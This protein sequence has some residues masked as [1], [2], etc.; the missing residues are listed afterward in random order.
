MLARWHDNALCVPVVVVASRWTLKV[1]VLLAMNVVHPYDVICHVVVVVVVVVDDAF[2]VIEVSVEIGDHVSVVV[3]VVVDVAHH[4]L[5][6][7]EVL[8][9]VFHFDRLELLQVD[10]AAWR[11]GWRLVARVVDWR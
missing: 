7:V 9:H 10:G 11:H 6:C 8:F 4:C 3:V 5:S 2:R 1:L